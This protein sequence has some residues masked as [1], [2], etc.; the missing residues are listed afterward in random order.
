MDTVTLILIAVGLSMDTLAVSVA[1]GFAM[2]PCRMR[3]AL[4]MAFSFGF[5]QAMM[6]LLGWVGGTTLKQI[7]AGYDHWVAFGLLTMI[8]SR[9]IY[10]SVKN[11]KP[12]DS[13]PMKW[14]FLLALSLATSI[15]ALA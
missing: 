5:F 13:N 14:H 11:E 6:P 2:N 8:G 15:D 3:N 4:R 9:M 7:I 10:Q 12:Y 1:S